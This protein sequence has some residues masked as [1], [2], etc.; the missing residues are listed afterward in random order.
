MEIFPEL[1]GE[2]GKFIIIIRDYTAG[3]SSKKKKKKSSDINDMNSPNKQFDLLD[4]V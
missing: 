3:R 1:L 2:I 4:I